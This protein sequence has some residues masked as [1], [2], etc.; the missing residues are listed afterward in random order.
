MDFILLSNTRYS[1]LENRKSTLSLSDMKVID[2]CLWNDRNLIL[3]LYVQNTKALKGV[4]NIDSH[5]I[6]LFTFPY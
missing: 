2:I 6:I 5:E 4:L 1:I 3:K